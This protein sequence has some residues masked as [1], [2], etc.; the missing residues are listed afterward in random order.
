MG[1]GQSR[2]QV[3]PDEAECTAMCRSVGDRL[4][5]RT[6]YPNAKFISA[7]QNIYTA[8]ASATDHVVSGR[9]KRGESEVVVQSG[10]L[11]HSGRHR[12]P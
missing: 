11:L 2:L 5:Y 1:L 12:P 6:H 4:K 3:H 10:R 8:S 9:T 7:S